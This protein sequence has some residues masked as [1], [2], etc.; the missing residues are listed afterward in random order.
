MTITLNYYVSFYNIHDKYLKITITL[1]IQVET[2]L[3]AG[4][5]NDM[6]EIMELLLQDTYLDTMFIQDFPFY[7]NFAY[8]V[9]K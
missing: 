1:L 7:F 9:Y 6:Q 4:W 2:E 5:K 8:S 3:Y